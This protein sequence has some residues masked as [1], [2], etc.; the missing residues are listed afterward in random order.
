MPASSRMVVTRAVKPLLRPPAPRA[1]ARRTAA[2]HAAAPRAAPGAGGDVALGQRR[3]DDVAGGQV[4]V[5]RDSGRVGEGER[6]H[7][8][9]HDGVDLVLGAS[10]LALAGG[11]SDR[12]DQV[13]RQPACPAR[14]QGR[15]GVAE[16]LQVLDQGEQ[17]GPQLAPATGPGFCLYFRVRPSRNSATVAGWG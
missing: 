12:G 5:G 17:R 2:P 15:V 1:A 8:G 6:R 10:Q 3:G 9:A 16:R 11:G 7:V 13:R 14:S 4:A